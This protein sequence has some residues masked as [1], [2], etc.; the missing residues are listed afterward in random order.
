MAHPEIAFGYFLSKAIYVRIASLLIGAHSIAHYFLVGYSW[1]SD[2][3]SFPYSS[4]L[5]VNVLVYALT[6]SNATFKNDFYSFHLVIWIMGSY[7]PVTLLL[8]WS[9][10]SKEQKRM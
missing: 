3:Y 5:C 8:N 10:Y 7:G 9:N 4:Y 6:F 1:V 2:V